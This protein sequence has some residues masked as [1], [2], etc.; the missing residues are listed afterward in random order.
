MPLDCFSVSYEKYLM[1]IGVV[2]PSLVASISKIICLFFIDLYFVNHLKLGMKVVAFDFQYFY[3]VLRLS[4]SSHLIPRHFI[5][6]CIH[7][8][9]I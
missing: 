1:S 6:L 8:F 5:Q 4:R 9:R 7:T 3:L 2:E